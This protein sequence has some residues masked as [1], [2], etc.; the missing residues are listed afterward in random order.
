M[1][2][3]PGADAAGPG[4]QPQPRRPRC[5]G[6]FARHGTALDNEVRP[7]RRSVQVITGPERWF[8]Q[9]LDFM[10]VQSTMYASS[11]VGASTFRRRMSNHIQFYAYNKK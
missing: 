10:S 8:E 7:L 6:G 5:P 9:Q 11:L 1:A 4:A 3:V 2:G